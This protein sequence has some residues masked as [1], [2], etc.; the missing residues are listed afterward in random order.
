MLCQSTVQE[1]EISHVETGW[2]GRKH[3]YVITQ[4]SCTHTTSCKATFV[5]DCKQYK[6]LDTVEEQQEQW[7]I[8]HSSVEKLA[9]SQ[10]S[11]V[12]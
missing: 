11:K 6:H 12:Q 8:T 5:P 3:E 4:H 7:A 10:T 1:R 2:K 9:I